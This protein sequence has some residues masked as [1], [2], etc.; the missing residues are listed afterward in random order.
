VELND[1][2]KQQMEKQ[3]NFYY[4]T[5]TV[6]LEPGQ[7]VQFWKLY[8]RIAFGSSGEDA[9]IVQR[10]F[11]SP[12]WKDVLQWGAGMKVALD[13]DLGYTIGIDP[14]AIPN[15]KIPAEIKAKVVNANDLHGVIAIPNFQ[16]SLGRAE[17]AA[18]GVSN[19]YCFW[20]IDKPELKQQ[21]DIQFSVI[22]KVP[23]S[24]TTLEMKA[25]THAEPSFPW[26]TAQLRDVFEYLSDRLKDLLRRNDAERTG[27][28]RLPIGDAE[29]WTLTLPD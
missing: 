21:Y 13:G 8:T 19:Q 10:I 1:I 3:Y 16:Y 7:G 5:L 26:L 12:E 28:D 27:K 2:W 18:G 4:L 24:M 17:I 29:Q 11:P 9:P 25:M 22:F 20:R 23:Q 15:L 14:I 6:T